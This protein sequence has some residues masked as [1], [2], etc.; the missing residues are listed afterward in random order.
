[1]AVPATEE[2]SKA[3]IIRWL[4]KEAATPSG[5]VASFFERGETDG[6]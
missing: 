2:I 3:R 1:M 6:S 5:V 4:D